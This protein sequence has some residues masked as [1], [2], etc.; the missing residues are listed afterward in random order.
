MFGKRLG[1]HRGKHKKK[2]NDNDSDKNPFRLSVSEHGIAFP[3]RTQGTLP[4]FFGQ[5]Y[6]TKRQK[7]QA[8]IHISERF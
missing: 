5:H 3:Q 8:P 2:N 1:G 6:Y 7:T 4:Y